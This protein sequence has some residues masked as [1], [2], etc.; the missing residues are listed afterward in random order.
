M[1]TSKSL[2]PVTHCIF[3]LD[4]TLID[5]ESVYQKVFRDICKSFGKDYTV[6]VQMKVLGTTKETSA[7]TMITELGLPVSLKELLDILDGICPKL[8]TTLDLMPGV[9]K[10]VRH[11]HATNIP[12]CIATSSGQDMAELKMS[13]R[14]EL[15][16]LFHHKVYGGTDQEVLHGKPAPDIFLIAANR[17]P[18]KPEPNKCLVFEDSP[19]GVRAGVLA[20]MQVVM[21]PDKL[22]KDEL[23]KEATI[24]LNSLEEFQP[25]M[26][27]LPKYSN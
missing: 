24:V 15:F 1:T 6:D 20:N 22:V 26:F 4:G 23:R 17:F 11:L 18:D 21:T 5:T 12:F 14:K 10:L 7:Q 9:E 27:G 16:N 19:N 3:D 13:S 2:T 8:V 25:E